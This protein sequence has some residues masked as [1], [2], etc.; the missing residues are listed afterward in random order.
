MNIASH[1]DLHR[2]RYANIQRQAGEP[3]FFDAANQLAACGDWCIEGRVEAAFLS[4]QAL[5][6]KFKANL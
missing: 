3:C 2:W 1:K 6:E 5:A 4:G